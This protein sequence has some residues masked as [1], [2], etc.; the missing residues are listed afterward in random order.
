MEETFSSCNIQIFRD[1]HMHGGRERKGGC[2]ATNCK[3]KHAIG[4]HNPTF[5]MCLQTRA[6]M[7]KV[8]KGMEV[9]LAGDGHDYEV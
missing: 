1:Q 9:K 3:K 2:T 4:R 6:M 5:L 7:M 8:S